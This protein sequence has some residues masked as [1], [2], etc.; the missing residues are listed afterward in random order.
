M[1]I[2][3]E[4]LRYLVAGGAAAATHLAVL[5]GLV[6]LS[7]APKPMAS[8]IG[9]CC[10]IPVNYIIQHRYVFQRSR[11]HSYYFV[12]YLAVTLTLMMVNVILFWIF[13][14]IFGIFYIL[15]QILVIGVIVIVNFLL[16]RAFTF[17]DRQAR[18]A[19]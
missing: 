3:T 4:F 1:K 5:A 10:A 17:A 19:R 11:G 6:Q 8:A 12:R 7:G 18:F 15:S 16:N 14:E 9:F 13:T 2:A